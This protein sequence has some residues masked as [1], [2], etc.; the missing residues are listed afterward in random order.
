[1]DKGLSYLVDF[2]KETTNCFTC[3]SYSAAELKMRSLLLT[4]RNLFFSNERQNAEN[5]TGQ[6]VGLAERS[7]ERETLVQIYYV[8]K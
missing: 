2:I 8:R 5:R 3:Y 6:A 7:Q 1:L 4:L